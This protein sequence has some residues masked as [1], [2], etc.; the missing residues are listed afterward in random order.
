MCSRLKRLVGKGFVILVLAF[1][2][3][4]F[5]WL[6]TETVLF[7]IALIRVFLNLVM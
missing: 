2:V 4:V 1:G 5:P 6:Y 3:V 7:F